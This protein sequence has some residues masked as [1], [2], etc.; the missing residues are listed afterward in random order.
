MKNQMAKRLIKGLDLIK[1]IDE[2]FK[3]KH[4]L[5]NP[6]LETCRKCHQM[7]MLSVNCLCGPCEVDD[8]KRLEFLY[9]CEIA[10]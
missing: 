10:L 7:M 4:V 8:D 9:Y 6:E 3:T 1:E 5:Y 2:H